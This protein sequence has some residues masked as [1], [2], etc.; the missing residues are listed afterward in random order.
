ML[1]SVRASVVYASEMGSLPVSCSSASLLLLL[2]T[3][4]HLHLVLFE[5]VEQATN[6]GLP[7]VHLCANLLPLLH[8]EFAM[9]CHDHIDCSIELVH[10]RLTQ[11]AVHSIDHIALHFTLVNLKL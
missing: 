11:S 1:L 6:T 10:L 7:E 5:L 9:D 3:A 8:S 4:G 2:D